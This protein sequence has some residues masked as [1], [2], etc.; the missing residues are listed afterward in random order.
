MKNDFLYQKLHPLY[1]R[2]QQIT[3]LH[4]LDGRLFI[5]LTSAPK[6]ATNS[7]SDQKSAWDDSAFELVADLIIAF[8]QK[9]IGTACARAVALGM[10]NAL[11]RRSCAEF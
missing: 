3:M 11:Q 1:R 2:I 6:S 7:L 10:H 9:V 4:G 5:V 8:R